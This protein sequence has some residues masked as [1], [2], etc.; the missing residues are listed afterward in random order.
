[1]A[2]VDDLDEGL[3]VGAASN[4]LSTHGL[5]DLQGGAFD[6]DDQG[7]TEGLVG[8]LFAIIEM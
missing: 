7:A 8:G 4:T 1:M 6:T 3:D 2:V 5:G